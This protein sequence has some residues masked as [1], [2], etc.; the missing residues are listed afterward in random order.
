VEGYSPVVGVSGVRAIRRVHR[1]GVFTDSVL[2][3]PENHRVICSLVCP[4]PAR[5]NCVKRIP[6]KERFICTEADTCSL[7]GV[8]VG[9]RAVHRKP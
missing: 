3:A 2:E 8:R 4:T 5:G 6:F 7:F 9:S 1:Q